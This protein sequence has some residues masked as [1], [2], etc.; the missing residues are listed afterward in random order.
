M[1]IKKSTPWLGISWASDDFSLSAPDMEKAF[2]QCFS[3]RSL[4]GGNTVYKF[5]GQKESERASEREREREREREERGE[6]ERSSA[7]HE[8]ICGD[9]SFGSFLVPEI[10]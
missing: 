2:I 5:W 8:K 1:V 9:S 4:T 6:R 7:K 3:W 10:W